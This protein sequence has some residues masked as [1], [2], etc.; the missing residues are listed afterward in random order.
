MNIR[1]RSALSL[2]EI[3]IVLGLLII[4]LLAVY[5]LLVSGMIMG[6]ELTE[7]LKLL[8]DVRAVVENIARDV[9]NAHVVL[10][11][12]TGWPDHSLLLACYTKDEMTSRINDNPRENFPFAEPTGASEVR[13][14]VTR[15]IYSLDE[16]KQEVTRTETI[17]HLQCTTETDRERITKYEFQAGTSAP[18]ERRLAKNVTRFDLSYLALESSGPSLLTTGSPI[19]KT[20]CVGLAITAEFKKGLYARRPGVTPTRRLPKVEIVTKFW[21]SRRQADVV[22]PEYTSSADDDLRY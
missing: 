6:D 1:R 5:Q 11:P 8:V 12:A 3:I 13:I 14:G 19:H 4:I 17:G 21:P 18:K 22:Y 16:T 9:A 20:A 2:A 7:E 10:P 15:V